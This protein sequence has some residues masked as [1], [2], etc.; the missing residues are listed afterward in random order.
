MDVDDDVCIQIN[1]EEHRTMNSA[2]LIQNDNR[3][4]AVNVVGMDPQIA[5][6]LQD[7]LNKS[8]QRV[9][10]LQAHADHI[11]QA[12]AASEQSLR[13]TA[14]ATH[15]AVLAGIRA[16][17]A[18]QL[19]ELQARLDKSQAAL[20]ETE[21]HC[22]EVEQSYLGLLEPVK[23]ELS[24]MR[25]EYDA[26][27]QERDRAMNCADQAAAQAKADAERASKAEAEAEAAA[28]RARTAEEAAQD[29]GAREKDA[30]EKAERARQTSLHNQREA[31][32][33]CEKVQHKYRLVKGQLKAAEAQAN[34]DSSSAGVVGGG[35][36][37]AAG[38]TNGGGRNAPA[39]VV[40]GGGSSA[41]VALT[42]DQIKALQ[43]ENNK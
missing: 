43:D 3:S 11:Q 20:V 31:K 23:N 30:E 8:N 39:T 33:Y 16:S 26:C 21:K 14:E 17:Y 28:E 10:A 19:S 9:S 5:L 27:A 32:E 34:G 2:T 15:E 37:S 42:S 13:S 35:G 40:G 18:V 41:G 4:M 12:A 36:S 22:A 6:G 29:A 1:V 7:Q 25:G 38:A 24:S